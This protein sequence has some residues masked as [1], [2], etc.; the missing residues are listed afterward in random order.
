MQPPDPLAIVGTTIAGKYRVDAMLGEGGAGVVYRGQNLLLGEPVAIKFVKPGENSVPLQEHSFFKEAK[1]LF[2][3]AHP[4]I[5]RMYDLGEHQTP[6]G[7][8]TYLVLEYIDGVSLDAEIRRRAAA[9][10]SFSSADIQRI[11]SA[12]LEA[13]SFAHAKKITHRDLKPSNVMLSRDGTVKMLDFGTARLSDQATRLTAHFTPRYAAP[14]QWDPARGT[15]GPWTDVYAL[16]LILYEMGT[17]HTAAKGDDL[18]TIIRSVL[19]VDRPS[20]RSARPD[21]LFLE[22]VLAKALALETSARYPSADAMLHGLRA[23]FEATGS[24]P[25]HGTASPSRAN[26]TAS[27]A[28][29][30]PLSQE[31]PLKSTLAI[32]HATSAMKR[33]SAPP[34]GAG[35]TLPLNSPALG[36][37]R[38]S[39]LLRQP[40]PPGA[41]STLFVPELHRPPAPSAPIIEKKRP[42]WLLGLIPIAL[43]AI[44]G[45]VYL[46]LRSR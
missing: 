44:V 34:P 12:V 43:C 15:R 29:T 36:E 4:N 41:P 28:Q 18:P 32:H 33:P 7:L 6:K 10:G 11:F 3:L 40:V 16:G 37:G 39:T 19:A 35:M 31:N 27:L 24:G 46:L 26:H 1:M 25:H 21:L 13:A 30:A 38:P 20:F 5:V 23:A 9:H 17:L 22:P 14:E 42:L 8:V 2:S 45:V